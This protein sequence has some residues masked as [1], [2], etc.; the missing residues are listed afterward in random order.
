MHHLPGHYPGHF[1]EAGVLFAGELMLLGFSGHIPDD[2]PLLENANDYSGT[3]TLIKKPS[4]H[5]A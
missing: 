3:P 1:K 4:K 2:V 5:L